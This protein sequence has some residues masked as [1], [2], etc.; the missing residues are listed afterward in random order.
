MRLIELFSGTGSVGRPWRVAGHT[1]ISV[2]IDGRFG[3]E[4]VGDIMELS[5]CELTTTQDVMQLG[6]VSDT[7]PPD[8]MQL[9]GASDAPPPDVIWASP[10]C[11][12]Y[13]CARTNAKTIRNLE[14]ADALVN[15][16]WA[17]T[18]HFKKVN[19]A[20]IWFIENPDTSLLWKRFKFPEYVR[21]DYCQYGEPYRKRTRIATNIQ[22]VPRALC[23]P[24]TCSRCVNG[25]HL[26]TAQKG[27]SM[28]G[29]VRVTGDNCS[30]D[31]LHGLP[32]ELTDEILRIS[33]IL[34]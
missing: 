22:W 8:V 20:L 17:I 28:R 5:C 14:L 33:S 9:G 24:K 30:L 10:P 16:T 11:E 32:Q 15:K 1:V 27:P 7:T 25:K 4:I 18:E 13:S 31:Q 34:S 26:Q 12:Q 6:G 3:A 21:L 19:P 2:D 29:G 23:N